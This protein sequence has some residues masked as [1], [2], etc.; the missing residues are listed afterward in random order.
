VRRPFRGN[1]PD[2]VPGRNERKGVRQVIGEEKYEMKN[3]P[4]RRALLVGAALVAVLG[5]FAASTPA[6][7]SRTGWEHR[8]K[9]GYG[10][11]LGVTASGYIGQW[12]CTNGDD[13]IWHYDT[14]NHL[15]NRKNQCITGQHGKE[16]QGERLVTFGPECIHFTFDILGT[17]VDEDHQELTIGIYGG[18]PH[19]GDGAVLWGIN[20][21]ADQ[22]W[23]FDDTYN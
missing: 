15:Y 18:H 10:K 22:R 3:N 4:L 5:A 20:S 13:Q 7:A 1:E 9:N 8:I 6:Y 12:T 19:D 14:Q 21:N 17:L 11:C 16:V 2:R 23:E